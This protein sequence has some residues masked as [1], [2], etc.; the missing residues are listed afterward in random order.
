MHLLEDIGAEVDNKPRNRV[1]VKL[2][3][4]SAAFRHAHHDL[5]KEEI[6]IFEV[7]CL[8]FEISG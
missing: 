7:G 6:L 5:P 4:H 8:L 2:N 3:G 1:G